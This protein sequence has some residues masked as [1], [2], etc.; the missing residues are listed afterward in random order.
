MEICARCWPN[1]LILARAKPMVISK[2]GVTRLNQ[3]EFQQLMFV[4]T[5]T[6]DLVVIYANIVSNCS[7]W[8]F[9]LYQFGCP[10][11]DADSDADAT[12]W[13][14]CSIDGWDLER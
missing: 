5:L 14:Y 10:V 9:L 2:W 1:G 7:M 4:M 12:D 11:V 8:R 6:V 13:R 3:Q